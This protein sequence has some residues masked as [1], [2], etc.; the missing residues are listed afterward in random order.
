MK[1]NEKKITAKEKAAKAVKGALITSKPYETGI[2]FLYHTRMF[3]LWL[4]NYASESELI[5]ATVKSETGLAIKPNKGSIVPENWLAT[6]A[7]NTTGRAETVRLFDASGEYTGLRFAF[8]S[9]KFKYQGWNAGEK[10]CKAIAET[11]GL[12]ETATMQVRQGK[13][14]YFWND[15][16]SILQAY[17]LK[18]FEK[19]NGE[20]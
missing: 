8:A 14:A 19:E 3:L 10:L 11:L 16:F 9:P 15:D 13:K 6:C 17:F 1:K 12:P 2:G 4:L 20:A 18:R 5:K 7:A